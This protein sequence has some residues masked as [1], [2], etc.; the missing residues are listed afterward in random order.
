MT[1]PHDLSYSMQFIEYNKENHPILNQIYDILSELEAQD[2][3]IT[4]IKV[5]LHMGI[6][7]NKKAIVMPGVTTT[8]HLMTR[9]NQQPMCTNA[10]YRKQ[11]LTIKLC[12]VECPQE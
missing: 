4:L 12:L 11:T 6:K 2:K 5:P 7:E 10:A 1:L 9:N 3:K 8:R